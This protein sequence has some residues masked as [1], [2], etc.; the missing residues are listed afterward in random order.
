MEDNNQSSSRDNGLFYILKVAQRIS[1]FKCLS[2]CWLRIVKP[3]TVVF[4]TRP[5][6][7]IHA[8]VPHARPRTHMHAHA[9]PRMSRLAHAR[10]C[11]PMQVNAR[12]RTPM[13]AHKHTYTPMYAHKHTCTATCMCHH[14]FM[15]VCPAVAYSLP[16]SYSE[17]LAMN[18]C[19]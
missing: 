18:V 8:L 11:T 9:Y 17:K 14:V 19:V 15:K 13:H 1:L 4:H 10:L 6:T 7:S 2:D 12:P 16:S 3:L 5:C